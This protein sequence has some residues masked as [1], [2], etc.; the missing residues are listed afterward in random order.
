MKIIEE[1]RREQ[2]KKFRDE[3]RLWANTQLFQK[4]ITKAHMAR[5]LEIPRSR[6]SEA[7]GGTGDC[8]KYIPMI[9]EYLGEDE[10]KYLEYLEIY[11]EKNDTKECVMQG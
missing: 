9:I 7:I 6:V 4:G 11:G 5:E 1:D 10:G 2:R 8:V 3:F